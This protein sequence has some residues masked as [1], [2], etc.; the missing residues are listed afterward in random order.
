MLGIIWL[1]I[2]GADAGLGQVRRPVKKAEALHTSQYVSVLPEALNHHDIKVG[3]KRA[4]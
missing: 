3:I 4:K 2:T 1:E